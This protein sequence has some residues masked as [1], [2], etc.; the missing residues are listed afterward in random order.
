MNLV[1]NFSMTGDKFMSQLYLRQPGF[2]YSA[3]VLFTK[4]HER[5]QNFKET[6]NLNY[7]YQNELGKACFGHD[8]AHANSN[9]L[10][11]RTVAH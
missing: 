11:K 1:I 6:G 3:C 4:H 8:A 10:A 7:T 2:A 9:G 5:I